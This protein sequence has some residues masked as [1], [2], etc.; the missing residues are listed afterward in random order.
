MGHSVYG[1]SNTMFEYIKTL[2]KVVQEVSPCTNT[3]IHVD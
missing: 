3:F 2:Q 1:L